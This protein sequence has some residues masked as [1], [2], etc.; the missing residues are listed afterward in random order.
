MGN[1]RAEFVPIKDRPR[2]ELP[3]GARVAAMLVMNVEQTE[4]DH[5][6]GRPLN[7][8]PPGR[9]RLPD[10]PNFSWFE[11][12]LRAGF[13]RILDVCRRMSVPITMTLNGSVCDSYPQ[14][15]QAALD[16]GWDVVG[17]G[18]Y[19]RPLTV[20][21]DERAAIRRA[22]DVIESFAGSRPKGWLGPA[23]AE[24][25]DT[26]ELL[27]DEGVEF[28][29]DWVNDDQPYEL[30]V[31]NGKLLSIPYSNELNDLGVYVRQGHAGRAL[32]DRVEDHLDTLIGDEPETARVM[33]V[34]LHPFV[35]GQPHRFPYFVKILELIMNTP[36]A[37]PMTATEI[38]RWHREQTGG[39]G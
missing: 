10:V 4:F 37:I 27:V 7:P 5:F 12:G 23:L 31:A 32:L 18:Y 34:G 36:G 3:R 16:A 25:A 28:V 9:E 39:A 1:P 6:V 17:H 20:E 38:F 22:L 19:Q 2:L 24:T 33:A 30:N 8:P 14:V 15:A 21:Q 13:W 35:M 11:Y 26:P 29:L